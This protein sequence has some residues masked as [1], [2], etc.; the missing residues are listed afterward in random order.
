MTIPGLVAER[1]VL[2]CASAEAI[3]ANAFYQNLTSALSGTQEYM[4]AEK[5]YELHS[6]GTAELVVVDTPPSRHALDFVDAPDRLLRLLD[7]R[8]YRLLTTPTR[9]VLRAVGAATRIFLRTL[10]RVVGRQVIDDAIAFFAA[11]EGM[12]DGFRR[13]AVAVREL[14]TDGRSAFVVVTSPRADA[15][16]ESA[17]LA[18][19]LADL[20]IGV[21]AV[22]VNQLHGDPLAALTDEDREALQ[23]AGGPHWQNVSE[24]AALA[25]R[26]RAQLDQLPKNLL[27]APTVEVPML[28]EDISDVSGLERFAATL[29]PW[30]GS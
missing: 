22:V 16:L 24:L 17:D 18:K 28:S 21:D 2:V 25:T 23:R 10:S 14:L 1:E 6:E 4:A 19:R 15:I 9:G 20:R 3:I 30:P 11:F 7:N 26:E 5:L 13:R 12:E 29:G 27:V 8:F